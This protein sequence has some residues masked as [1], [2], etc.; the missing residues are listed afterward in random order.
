MSIDLFHRTTSETEY[1]SLTRD[2]RP[3]FQTDGTVVI[4]KPEN[5]QQRDGCK[6]KKWRC[7][8]MIMW[9]WN[10]NVCYDML[11]TCIY[12]H[13]HNAEINWVTTYNVRET[14]SCVY[15]INMHVSCVFIVMLN[16]RVVNELLLLCAVFSGLFAFS[17]VNIFILFYFQYIFIFS[18]RR[19]SVHGTR[20]TSINLWQWPYFCSWNKYG[21]WVIWA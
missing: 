10:D 8:C 5:P 6:R 11:C 7:V 12:L 4:Q 19:Y 2:L 9:Q 3:L 17:A 21:Q 14:F 15:H 16:C 13:V 1:T 20:T 18:H